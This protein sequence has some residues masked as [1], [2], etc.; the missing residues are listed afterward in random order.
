MKK[1]ALIYTVTKDNTKALF[2]SAQQ[3]GVDAIFWCVE[4]KD[5]DMVVPHNVTLLVEDFSRGGNLNGKVF[6][7]NHARI[8]RKIFDM[9]YD[10][11]A[12][13]D[14]D[15]LILNSSM[16]DPLPTDVPA[17]RGMRLN[18]VLSGGAYVVNALMPDA[19][20]RFIADHDF[21]PNPVKTWD[22]FSQKVERLSY[23]YSGPV[24]NMG[25]WTDSAEDLCVHRAVIHAN[26]YLDYL[27]Q[28]RMFWLNSDAPDVT[29]V[30][31]F[32]VISPSYKG[33]LNVSAPFLVKKM[34]E[35]F[36]Q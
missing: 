3:L 24:R 29:S 2:F 30:P 28:A 11:V 25:R 21:P 1:A 17:L 4:T 10:L 18:G 16:L 15:S 33:D 14:S 35:N 12:K 32:S 13:I 26:G 6:L 8:L 22:G 20:E 7:L 5:K 23:S 34:K 27:A 19:I 9:G 36:K 31:F